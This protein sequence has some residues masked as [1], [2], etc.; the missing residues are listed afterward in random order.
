MSDPSRRAHLSDRLWCLPPGTA[1][2]VRLIVDDAFGGYWLGFQGYICE[3][4]Q[5]GGHEW[6]F[7]GQLGFGG[8]LHLNGARLYVGCYPGD[9]TPGLDREIDRVNEALAAVAREALNG[10]EA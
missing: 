2:K 6:R 1:E 4:Q 5:F 9:R 7:Q 10:G 3:P 8:K